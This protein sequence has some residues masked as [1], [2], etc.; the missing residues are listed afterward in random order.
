MA[1]QQLA[2]RRIDQVHST[3]KPR[4]DPGKLIP[5]TTVALAHHSNLRAF[6]IKNR[7]AGVAL[8]NVFITARHTGT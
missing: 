5:G 8:A 7:T 6:P 3:G 2:N 1:N 4:V